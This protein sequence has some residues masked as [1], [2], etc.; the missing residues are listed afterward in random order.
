VKTGSFSTCLML[1]IAACGQARQDVRSLMTPDLEGHMSGNGK[2]AGGQ[3]DSAASEGDS[4]SPQPPSPAPVGP[5]V[6]EACDGRFG[7]PS[8]GAAPRCPAQSPS[9]GGACGVK[10][11]ACSYGSA[12]LPA[13][14]SLFECD[15]SVWKHS[16]TPL[17]EC[18]L[19]PHEE[20]PENT[21]KD[22]ESCLTSAYTSFVGCAEGDA[23]RCVCVANSSVGDPTQHLPGSWYC[24]GPPENQAC[25]ALCPQVGD[26]CEEAAL[27][28]SYITL[29]EL[30]R[31]G[32]SVFCFDGE[33]QA[34]Q[35]AACQ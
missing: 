5:C 8:P 17:T 33:W 30:G 35:D 26:G 18:D 24:V 19:V 15:G 4:A 27:E 2:D 7:R 29:C 9:D 34:G 28:C 25:P 32:G 3:T 12:R 20:C 13:C 31:T 23:L 14:R 22:F 10:G 16:L 1:V 6:G 21:P 11:L